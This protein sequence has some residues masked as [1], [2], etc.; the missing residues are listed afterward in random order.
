MRKMADEQDVS[1]FAGKAITN[2]RRRIARLQIAR[3]RKF[4]ERIAGAPEGFRGLF[5]PQF[6]AVP[7]DRRT[8]AAVGG[9]A[10]EQVD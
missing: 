10:G 4:R 9:R 5:R 8:H 1:G 3:R 6:P 7:H 2:P